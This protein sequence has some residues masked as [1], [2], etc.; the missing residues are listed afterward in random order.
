[1]CCVE[2]DCL[3]LA[4]DDFSRTS[5]MDN[6]NNFGFDEFTT[7]SSED[8]GFKELE[9]SASIM[10]YEKVLNISCSSSTLLEQ[11]KLVLED[12]FSDLT[13]EPPPAES[14]KTRRTH[15]TRKD[16]E[17]NNKLFP[18]A[19]PTEN[20]SYNQD[21]L[22]GFGKTVSAI[23]NPDVSE[24]STRVPGIVKMGTSD[25]EI[26][27]LFPNPF[28]TE[29]LSYNRHELLGFGKTVIVHPDL[30]EISTRIPGI[31]KMRGSDLEEAVADNCMKPIFHASD[32]P[33]I[34][35]NHEML[36]YLARNRH[37]I[38]PPK[39]WMEIKERLPQ[40]VYKNELQYEKVEVFTRDPLA[41]QD[42][43]EHRAFGIQV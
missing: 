42:Y 14:V 23:V 9:S 37:S 25:L 30:S 27:K 11:A 39:N 33:R 12:Y 13:F 2:V 31:V 21:E 4:W 43:I 38:S 32:I 8:E 40:T 18:N 35:Y 16:L 19:F 6:L 41:H 20:L 22:V 28:P 26:T 3:S 1:M 10:I 36:M 7:N 5:K 15:F 29:K 34:T 24:L 17:M